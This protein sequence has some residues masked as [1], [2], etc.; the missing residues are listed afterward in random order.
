[1]LAQKVARKYAKAL[2]LS[3][4][5]R[6]LIDQAY[7]QFQS[8]QQVIDTDP[9]ILHA[10]TGPRIPLEEKIGL[11]KRI[12]GSVMNPL[13]VEF[14]SVLTRKRRI[15]FL[16]EIAD[17]LGRLIET[18]KDIGRVTVTTAVELLPS[19]EERLRKSLEARSGQT[20]LL[21]KRVD[22]YVLGGMIVMMDGEV[23]DGSVRHGLNMLGEQ[24]AELKVH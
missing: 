20:I 7:E 10:L 1:M 18:E 8:L 19:E 22:P 13:H 14:L 12:F 16:P 4:K 11:I 17:E 6:N 24:L 2:F 21:E 15:G 3:I 23:I 5:E 9:G